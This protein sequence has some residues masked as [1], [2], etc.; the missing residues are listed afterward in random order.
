VVSM[1]YRLS[2]AILHFVTK[3]KRKPRFNAC[4]AWERFDQGN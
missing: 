3:M 1:T 2:G 4:K